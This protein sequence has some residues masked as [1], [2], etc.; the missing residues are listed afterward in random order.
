MKIVIAKAMK[1]IKVLESAIEA[2]KS[3]ASTLKIKEYIC[4][5][6]KSID[7]SIKLAHSDSVLVALKKELFE[8]ICTGAELEDIMVRNQC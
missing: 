8:L 1:G 3:T 5:L 7:D 4:F 6:I 2:K